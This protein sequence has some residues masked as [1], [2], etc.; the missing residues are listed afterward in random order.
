MYEDKLN[1][2][3]QSVWLLNMA[4]V[5]ENIRKTYKSHTHEEHIYEVPDTYIGSAEKDTIPVLV[6]NE[7]E[8]K[9]IEREAEIV[10]GL[11]KVFDEVLVNAIDHYTRIL[12]KKPPVAFPV[13]QIR[14][15]ANRETGE[16]SIWNDGMGIDVIEHPDQKVYVPE[17]IFGKLLTSTNYDKDED[18]ITGGKNGYGAKLANIF[19]KSFTVET[20]D[21]TREKKYR[22]TWKNNMK[23]VG[24]PSIRSVKSAPY[25]KISWIPDYKRFGLRGLTKDITDVFHRR[26]LDCA[27]WCGASIKVKWNG[28]VV[29]CRNLIHYSKLVAGETPIIQ[30]KGNPRWNVIV[31]TTEKGEGF[32]QVSFVNGIHTSSG[33]KHVQHVTKQIVDALVSSVKKKTKHTI[34]SSA[35]KDCLLLIIQATIVNPSFKS[36]TKDELTT[37]VSKMGSKWV[38]DTKDVSQI[39]NKTDILDRLMEA[40]AVAEGKASSKTD[41]KKRSR[42]SGIPKLEDASYAG[43]K[44]STKCTLI[45]TEGDSAATTAISGL[46]VVGRDIYG[47]YP[48]KGKMINAKNASGSSLHTNSEIQDIKKIIG[49]ETGKKYKD[50]SGLRYGRIMIMTDQDHDGSHIKGLVMNMFHAEWP[51]LLELGF[52]VSMLTPIVKAKR[53][54][55]EVSFYTLFDYETWSC[56]EEIKNARPK[57]KVKYYK[58]LGTSTP[59]EAREY[60]KRIRGVSYVWDE[61]ASFNMDKAFKK[62]QE[63]DRKLWISEYDSSDVL[64]FTGAL[65]GEFK[66]IPVSDFINKEL[67]AYSHASNLRAIPNIV[68]GLKTSQRKILFGCLKRNLTSE[69]RVAQL[70]GYVSEHAAYHHGEASLNQAIIAM[71]QTFVGSNNV[72]ILEPIGQFGSRLLG[73]KDAS[74]PRYIHTHL[75]RLARSLFIPSDTPVLKHLDDD[76][77]PVEPQ[78]YSPVIPLILVNGSE[79]IGTGYSTS[80]PPH[81]PISIIRAL[82]SRLNKEDVFESVGNPW[83]RGYK[84]MI[85]PLSGSSGKKFVVSGIYEKV[86]ENT[87]VIKELP[88]GVWTKTYRESLEKMILGSPIASVSKKPPILKDVIDEYNDI[89]VRLTLEFLPGELS[90]LE[91]SGN[92]SKKLGLETTIHMTNMWCYNSDCKLQ[93]YDSADEILDDYYEA[94]LKTYSDRKEYQITELTKEYNMISAKAYFIMEVRRNAIDLKTD[95]IVLCNVLETYEKTLPKLNDKS[96]SDCLAEWKYLLNMPVRSLTDKKRSELLKQRDDIEI[97]LKELRSSSPEQLWLADLKIFEDTY[98]SFIE[99]RTIADKMTIEESNHRVKHT[100]RRRRRKKT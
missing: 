89:D 75:T 12:S 7:S 99:E 35:V 95:D 46:K 44:N 21:S 91:S 81:N 70:A 3:K 17:M 34:R 49:L 23:E 97:K 74:S 54:S 37:P 8:T 30:L 38:L 45:L 93:K 62:G 31:S 27:A 39:L 18:R 84:G 63:D 1:H 47:V 83:W 66:S 41:G 53:G 82:R 20:V 33:G 92:L 73:G 61:D 96:D 68:D 65:S 71:A 85:E 25:T 2:F 79:G 22:Q 90:K 80:I 76:G 98:M 72:N 64:K 9:I 67:I 24:K 29:P 86:N 14:V 57:W 78:W 10:P 100:V 5:T 48:L 42:I 60:F 16:I 77:L 51:E 87:I 88:I 94:R 15:T 59:A 40:H 43:S 50:V 11:Y 26:V 6:L 4:V 69:I 32:R 55:E 36:Q 28:K 52:V 58:G 13:K 56:R 19:A